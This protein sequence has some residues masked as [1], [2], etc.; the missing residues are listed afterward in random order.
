MFRRT[1][2]EFMSIVHAQVCGAQIREEIKILLKRIAMARTEA[3]ERA[4]KTTA[5]TKDA[6]VQTA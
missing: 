1:V 2:S 3:T 5:A 4:T 6:N